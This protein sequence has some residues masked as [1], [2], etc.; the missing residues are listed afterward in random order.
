MNNAQT[1]RIGKYLFIFPESLKYEIIN[2]PGDYYG[3]IFYD[4][5]YKYQ[6]LDC[7][8]G[9]RLLINGEEGEYRDLPFHNGT[10]HFLPDCIQIEF[11]T[12]L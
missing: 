11:L 5:K 6:V 12:G 2:E 8:L 10:T 9:Y 4:G 7:K 3:V 1:V